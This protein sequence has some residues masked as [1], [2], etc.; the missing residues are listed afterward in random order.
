MSNNVKSTNKVQ[1]GIDE[2]DSLLDGNDPGFVFHTRK[3]PTPP[4]YSAMEIKSI[5]KQIPATQRV[6]AQIIS[7]SPRTVEAWESGKS[8][9][10][11]TTRRLIQIIAQ[12]P[13]AAKN[14][15]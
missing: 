4:N 6:F 3:I 8:T 2:L 10:T 14:F 1:I 12:N 5:R 15:I 7:A 9:P 11:G 13:K